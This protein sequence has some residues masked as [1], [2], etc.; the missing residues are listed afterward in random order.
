MRTIVAFILLTVVM[1]SC[2]LDYRIDRREDRLIGRWVFDRA[3]YKDNGALFREN[4]FNEYAGDV[5]EFYPNFE[6]AY[7]DASQ[8]YTYWGEWEIFAQRGGGSGDDDTEFF[9]D[10]YF[11]DDRGFESF[12]Y[13]GEVKR[14]SRNVLRIEA[15]DRF[16]EYTFRLERIY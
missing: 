13:I 8:R 5:I 12:S 3:F 15:Y 10:M 1:S 11:Y 14:L 2:S 6:A 16:G 7:D 4:I 9:L